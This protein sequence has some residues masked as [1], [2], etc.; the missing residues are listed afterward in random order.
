MIKFFLEYR[1]T[2]VSFEKGTFSAKS[3]GTHYKYESLLYKNFQILYAEK[4]YKTFLKILIRL[5]AES[6][7]KNLAIYLMPILTVDIFQKIANNINYQLS[8]QPALAFAIALKLDH[9][10]TK[11]YWRLQVIL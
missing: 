6:G 8:K 3:D 2:R 11:N 4:R 5:T 9:E 10:K 1:F 7:E